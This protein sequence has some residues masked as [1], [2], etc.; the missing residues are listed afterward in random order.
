[1]RTRRSNVFDIARGSPLKHCNLNLLGRYS[2]AAS[3][4]AAG[5]LRPL[6]DPDAQE[7]GGWPS[8]RAP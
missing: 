3:A 4:P 6:R 2:F 7:L 1:M 5:A 8:G